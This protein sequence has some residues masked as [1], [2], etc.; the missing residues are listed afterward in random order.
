MP[1][2]ERAN[3]RA[4]YLKHVPLSVLNE[5]AEKIKAKQKIEAEIKE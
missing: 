2:K 1:L 5:K 4:K 3:F